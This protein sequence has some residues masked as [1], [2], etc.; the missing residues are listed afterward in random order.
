[1]TRRSEQ[2]EAGFTVLEA[3]I[4]LTILSIVTA[5]VLSLISAGLRLNERSR[6]DLTSALQARAILNRVGLDILLEPGRHTGSLP[7]GCVWRLEITPFLDS[8]QQSSHQPQRLY[9]VQVQVSGP[10]SGSE[11]LVLRTLLR[12]AQQ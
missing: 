1:M 8:P 11:P 9:D 7:D 5:A 3:L 12:G 6:E 4:G 2:K 10:G